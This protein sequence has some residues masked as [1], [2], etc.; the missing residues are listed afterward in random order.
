MADTYVHALRPPFH[1]NNRYRVVDD[2]TVS[3]MGWTAA[4]GL[5]SLAARD[6]QVC[7]DPFNPRCGCVVI[8]TAE[9]AD[10][11]S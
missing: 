2:V 3:E 10:E 4:S 11:P 7:P 5:W 6:R 9:P 8:Q 1:P